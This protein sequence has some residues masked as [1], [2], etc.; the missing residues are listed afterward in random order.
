MVYLTDIIRIFKRQ[1]RLATSLS[2]DA[3]C[4]S[5]RQA[6]RIDTDPPD[7]RHRRRVSVAH[8]R[9]ARRQRVLSFS[10]LGLILDRLGMAYRRFGIET[11]RTPDVA[12]HHIPE[13]IS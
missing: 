13:E 5:W 12:A 8:R 2:R 4:R 11:L 6:L 1:G 7:Y 3:G 10:A 9:R